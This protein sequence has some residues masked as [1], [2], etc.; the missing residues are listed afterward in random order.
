M[1]LNIEIMPIFFI[2]KF[3]TFSE[4]CFNFRNYLLAV[5]FKGFLPV[6]PRVSIAAN[7]SGSHGD[8]YEGDC[9]LGCYVVECGG[10]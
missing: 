10:K 5:N 4:V 7:I 9:L 2:D 3:Y 1:F 8:E 6:E